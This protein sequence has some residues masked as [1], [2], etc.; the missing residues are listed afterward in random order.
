MMHDLTPKQ[1]LLANLMSE[2]SERC[3]C[4][5]WMQ[6]LEYVL[7]EALVNGERKYGQDTIT[8]QDINSLKE[9][10]EMTNSW[11]V[12]DDI[13]DEMPL[14]LSAWKEKFQID[15]QKDSELL[16]G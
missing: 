15:V 13:L 6:N 12:F 9:L 2:V 1:K 16:K 14:D 3:Y 5:G 7:W 4:A 10:S 11:I 8:Q